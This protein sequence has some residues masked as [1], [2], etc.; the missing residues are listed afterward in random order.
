MRLK[1][2]Q[3]FTTTTEDGMRF[4]IYAPSVGVRL[5]GWLRNTV[6]VKI[7]EVSGRQK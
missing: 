6:K 3:S 2:D 5:M 7:D 4:I 1:P